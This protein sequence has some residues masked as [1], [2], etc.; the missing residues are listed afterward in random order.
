MD[1]DDFDSL[2]QRLREFAEVRDDVHGCT[3]VARGRDA[4]SDLGSD[5]YAE[6]HIPNRK[7]MEL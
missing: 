6:R 7:R 4:V 2:K 3:S 1:H 5:H